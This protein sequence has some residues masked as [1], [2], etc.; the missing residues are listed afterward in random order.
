MR[1]AGIVSTILVTALWAAP[2]S[3][4]PMPG[5]PRF[6]PITAPLS[7]ALV[8]I[9]A[10][11]LVGVFLFV[12]PAEAPAALASYLIRDLAALKRFVHRAEKDIKRFRAISR[13]DKL[14]FL[15][16]V[17]LGI[18]GGRV[19]GKSVPKKWV[20]RVQEL[21]LVPSLD[22]RDISMRRGGGR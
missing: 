6:Q 1:L 17:G 7:E 5:T 22:Y 15:H 18:D 19:G 12:P 10:P 21:T 14:V 4:R 20:Q 3:A 16:L 13:W 8:V 9:K 2:A 11:K